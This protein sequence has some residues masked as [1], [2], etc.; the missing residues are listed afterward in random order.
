MPRILSKSSEAHPA[1]GWS[2]WL[3]TRIE[4]KDGLNFGLRHNSHTMEFAKT[5]R[6]NHGRYWRKRYEPAN[7]CISQGST[8]KIISNVWMVGWDKF[9]VTFTGCG[10]QA[11]SEFGCNLRR[12]KRNVRRTKSMNTTVKTRENCGQEICGFWP[13]GNPPNGSPDSGWS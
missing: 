8:E 5:P 12:C 2:R 10:T 4:T 7:H 3:K 13:E 9:E 6:M 11:P 1:R